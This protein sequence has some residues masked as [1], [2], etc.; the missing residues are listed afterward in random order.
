MSEEVLEET[1][2]I[3]PPVESV[4]NLEVKNEENEELESQSI[5]N[6]EENEE[7]I[8]EPLPEFNTELAQEKIFELIQSVS[9]IFLL[10]SIIF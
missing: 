1:P 3:D 8:D 5:I 10:Y 9:N 6:N 2:L 7:D 4:D